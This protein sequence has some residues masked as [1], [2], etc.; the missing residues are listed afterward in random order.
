MLNPNQLFT[1]YQQIRSN[2]IGLLSQR[3][4]I[5]QDMNDPN[6]ILQHLLNS[7]QV[8]QQQINNVMSMKNSPIIQALL[9]K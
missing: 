6:D 8:S 1:M 3:Y 2:P 9:N 7:G 4:S 5:P